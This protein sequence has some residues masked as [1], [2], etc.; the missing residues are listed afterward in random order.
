MPSFNN[1]RPEF[2]GRDE[3]SFDPAGIKENREAALFGV[4]EFLIDFEK[5]EGNRAAGFIEQMDVRE[6]FDVV[7]AME[8][9]GRLSDD[10]SPPAGTTRAGEDCQG[11]LLWCSKVSRGERR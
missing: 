3:A 7:L 2:V 8:V 10:G 6:R 11:G 9:I 4:P 5:G 1:G